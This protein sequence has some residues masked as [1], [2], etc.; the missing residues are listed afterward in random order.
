MLKESPQ[1]NLT[2][3]IEP[4]SVHAPESIVEQHY[5]DKTNAIIGWILQGGVILSAAI[6][7]FGLILMAFEPNKFAPQT[8]LSFPQS[9]AEVGRG[10]LVLNPQS[11]IAFGLL[12]LIATPIMR[13]AVSIMA[14]AVERDWRFVVLT[15][16]VLAI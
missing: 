7:I 5:S 12:L 8:L 15:V 10:L 3:T 1:K 13:V 9:F 6:I 2:Q 11:V 14:F 16:F 4:E